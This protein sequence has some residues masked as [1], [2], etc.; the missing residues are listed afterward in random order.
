M[1]DF[2][3]NID[4]FLSRNKKTLPYKIFQSGNDYLFRVGLLGN[5]QVMLL[6]I[7]VTNSRNVFNLECQPLQV[8]CSKDRI[9]YYEEAI[10]SFNKNSKIVNVRIDR[11]N[12][13]LIF[14]SARIL[15][16][17]NNEDNF[18]VDFKAVTSAC[19]TNAMKII[20]AGIKNKVFDKDLSFISDL[21][22]IT[23]VA[24]HYSEVSNILNLTQDIVNNII[25]EVGLKEK[26]H[27]FRNLEEDVTIMSCYPDDLDGKIQYLNGLLQAMISLEQIAINNGIEP[28]Q[29]DVLFQTMHKMELPQDIREKIIT[30][31]MNNQN[32]ALE[33]KNNILQS[34]IF[35]SAD[36]N[37]AILLF[38]DMG[39][40]DDDWYCED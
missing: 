7:Y 10:I 40:I 11:S 3:L 26:L 18:A 14:S 23:F 29:N 24:R 13:A 2:V 38:E 31:F 22:N 35:M 12:N 36:K 20:D 25:D 30:D 28:I 27:V 4:S 37:R 9:N 15:D 33:D 21:T 39:L 5:R 16:S 17:A 19:D 6:D 32:I 8:T 34:L 1:D